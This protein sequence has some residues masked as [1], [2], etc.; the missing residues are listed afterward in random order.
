VAGVT[1]DFARRWSTADAADI[2]YYPYVDHRLMLSLRFEAGGNPWRR[3]ARMTPGHVRLP[4]GEVEHPPVL[5]DDLVRGLL[6]QQDELSGDCGSVP[7]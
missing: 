2:R 6:R 3:R 7:P 1:Y 4:Y 5:L